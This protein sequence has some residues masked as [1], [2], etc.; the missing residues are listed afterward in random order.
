MSDD[1]YYTVLGI[2]ETARQ[3]EI[4]R[5]YRSFIEAY[6]VLSDST[7]RSSYDHQLA[8]HRQQN[9][10]EPSPTA[11][12]T[13]SLFWDDFPR[14]IRLSIGEA[15]EV[16]SGRLP[17]TRPLAQKLQSVLGGSAEFWMSHDFGEESRGVTPWFA[18]AG[19]VF[20]VGLGYTA[21]AIVAAVL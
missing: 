13:P 1:T 3:G 19:L 15:K 16:L 11:F 12:P 5:R 8:R 6:Q 9:A 18:M 20:F 4:E 14:Q 17:M 7:Q 10:P 2:P 21:F